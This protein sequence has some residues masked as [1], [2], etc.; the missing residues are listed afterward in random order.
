[1]THQMRNQNAS[2]EQK[3]READHKL[4]LREKELLDLQVGY[5][6]RLLYYMAFSFIFVCYLCSSFGFGLNALFEI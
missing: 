2:V 6:V 1:M 5:I 4:R 3:V